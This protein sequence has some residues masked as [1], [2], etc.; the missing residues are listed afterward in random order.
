MSSSKTALMAAVRSTVGRKVLTGVTGLGLV[1]F[2]IEHLYSNLLY[3]SS[4]PTKYNSNAHFLISFELI[5]VL[6]FG[7]LALFVV[8]VVVGVNI[9]L[10]KRKARPIGYT[11]YHSAG[12]PS[13]QSA[14]SRTMIITGLVLLVFLVI[15]II[16][17]KFGP[18]IKDG[19]VAMIDGEPVRDLKRLLDE[20]FQHPTYAF[21][22]TFAMILLGFH[23]RHGIWSAFQSLGA[24]NPRLS[25][26]VYTLGGVLA[27]LLAVGFLLL[28]LWIFFTL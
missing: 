1:V 21:G 14:S 7:L 4:D 19:Y 17:F 25:P 2:L 20:K 26:L 8:H 12:K 22:Y 9:Y 24:M 15:H 28:P 3:F 13:R 16:S 5:Y 11:E 10:R 6:E 18:G 23:V 27:V